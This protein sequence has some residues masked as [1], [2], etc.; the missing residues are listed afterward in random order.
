MN[1][2]K[3]LET[4]KRGGWRGRE[5]GENHSRTCW[6]LQIKSLFFNY[7]HIT[8]SSSMLGKEAVV[9]W[10]PAEITSMPISLP[11]FTWKN[12]SCQSTGMWASSLRL[13]A[14]TTRLLVWASVGRRCPQ[15]LP[16]HSTT[17]KANNIHVTSY[18]SPG[19]RSN[20]LQPAGDLR[21]GNLT[22]TSDGGRCQ[23]DFFIFSK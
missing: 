3:N 12:S 16:I 10:P 7:I 14:Q 11:A 15:S 13:S 5:R 6:M 18:F 22:R 1:I 23:L 19:H 4:D 8:R 9:C 2:D 20:K 17:S 21:L